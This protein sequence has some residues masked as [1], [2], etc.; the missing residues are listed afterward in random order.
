MAYSCTS[1]KR[2]LPPRI[3]IRKKFTI[4]SIL[5]REGLKTG[6]NLS[7]VTVKKYYDLAKKQFIETAVSEVIAWFQISN[8]FAG[9]TILEL[10]NFKLKSKKVSFTDF[11]LF[12]IQIIKMV[13]C[14]PLE[15][16]LPPKY[17]WNSI[18]KFSSLRIP[19]GLNSAKIHP[20]SNSFDLANKRLRT[21]IIM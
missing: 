11:R 5:W 4:S 14:T 15:W 1:L 19:G 21:G 10:P 13:S 8:F 20:E 16:S 6:Q 18:S 2:S 7:I 9:S 12:N 17:L 3:W